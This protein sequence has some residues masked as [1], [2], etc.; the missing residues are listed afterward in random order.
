[1]S[2]NKTLEEKFAEKQL[3]EEDME[4]VAGGS[5]EQTFADANM[6]DFF[7]ITD[8]KTVMDSAE[9]TWKNKDKRMA[10]LNAL[11]KVGIKC[12]IHPHHFDNEYYD[13]KTGKKISQKQAWK[14]MEKYARQHG[15]YS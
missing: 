12:T 11:S 4:M 8:N 2:E 13:K 1:M 14:I 15:L 5:Y 6:L 10:V 3:N 9:T 7:G